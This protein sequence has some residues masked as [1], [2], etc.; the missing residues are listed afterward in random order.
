MIW[1]Q[2]A[3]KLKKAVQDNLI[4]YFSRPAPSQYL[5]LSASSWAKNTIFYKAAEKEGI[6]LDIAELKPWEKEQRLA[7]WVNKQAAASRKLISYQV[8]QFLVKRLGNDQALLAKEL[9]KLICFSGERKEIVQQDVEALCHRQQVE[10]IWQLGE[11]LFRRDAG[12]SIQMVHALLMEGQSLLPLLRQI[13]SQYQTGYQICLLLGEGKQ[14]SDISQEFPY[15]KGQILERN[16]RQAQQYGLDLFK[17]GLIALDGAEL[18]VKN[19][20]VDE[21][22][23]AELLIMQLTMSKTP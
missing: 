9:E 20:P 6:I 10:T 8:C 21:K 5:L 12:A 18:R 17:K 3:D 16:M 22:I 23:I 19:S 7:E 1:V 2:Q 11:A 13:R 14:A 4:K 15:L